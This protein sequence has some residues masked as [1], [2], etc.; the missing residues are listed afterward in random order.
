MRRLILL[1]LGLGTLCQAIASQPV[2]DGATE[3]LYAA[4]KRITASGYTLF[5][6]ANALTI[7]Y[8]DTHTPR[9]DG[10][11]IRDVT[12]DNP[13]F[14]ESDL[15]WYG[16]PAF[17]RAD[18]EAMRRA[19]E[20]GAVVGYCWHLGGRLTGRFYAEG[21]GAADRDL[22]RRIVANPDRKTNPDLDWFL[23]K[24]DT[25]AIPVFRELS[26]PLVFRPFHEMTG[27][28]FWWGSGAG[29]ETYRQLYR[30]TVDYLRAAGIRNLLY[31]WAPDKDADF[32]YYPGDD[33]VDVLGYDGYEPGL[34]PYLTSEKLTRELGRIVAYAAAH[35]K[36]AAWT[37]VGLRTDPGESRMAYP[38]RVPDFW[39]RYVWDAVKRNPRTDRLAWIMCWYNADWNGDGGGCPFVPYAGMDKE[40]S[41]AA[42][43]DFQRL[44]HE[45]RILFESGMPPLEGDAADRALFIRPQDPVLAA[46]ERLTML[47][48][49]VCGWYRTDGVHW[50]SSDP[51]VARID[52]RSGEVEA[53]KAGVAILTVEREGYT[54]STRVVVLPENCKN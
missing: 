28:W 36:I 20:R 51:A 4:L 24:L 15:M 23:T 3:E 13:A 9:I 5:G 2:R 42:L 38:T 34:K 29:K 1:I 11:D 33:Y 12:G 25:L 6:M 49:P 41:A 52:A 48:G 26:F 19:H 44:F 35:D 31:C 47:G 39:T 43:A 21:E 50:S 18:L 54:A 53:L 16:D 32:G 7:S 27:D 40:G 10:S 17:R 45:N 8:N 30:L 46:G 14:V 22:A 37:E